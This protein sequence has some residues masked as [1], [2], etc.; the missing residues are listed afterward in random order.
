MGLLRRAAAGTMSDDLIVELAALHAAVSNALQAI[1]VLSEQSGLPREAFVER[2]LH[3]GTEAIALP[4]LR[5]VPPDR[6]EL[7]IDRARAR[8][9]EIIDSVYRAKRHLR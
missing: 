8:Y 2:L 3:A 6:Q 4:G 9:V 1:A 7:L 5:G